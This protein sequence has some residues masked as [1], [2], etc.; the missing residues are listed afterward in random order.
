MRS[1]FTYIA[2]LLLAVPLHAMP[3]REKP[4]GVNTGSDSIPIGLLVTDS[5]RTEIITAAQLA[6]DAANDQGGTGEVPF[7]LVVRSTEGP[8]GAGSKESVSLVYDDNV[9]VIVG[10][11]DGRNGHV[12]EQVATKS[13]LVYLETRATESTLSQ[14]FVPYFK[15]ILPNDDQQA[16]AI[17]QRVRRQ[18]GGRVA[19]LYDQVFDHLHAARSFT[20]MA[21]RTGHPDPMLL[22]VDTLGT[23]PG[24]LI[25]VLH[26]GHVNNLVVPYRTGVT[27]MMIQEVRQYLPQI[28]V[29]GTLGLTAAMVPGDPEWQK[30]EGVMAISPGSGT[31]AG[32]NLFSKK[33]Y[34]KTGEA[35]PVELVFTYDGVSMVLQAIR[36]AGTDRESVKNELSSMRYAGITGILSFDEMG[37]RIGKIH[38]YRIKEGQLVPGDPLSFR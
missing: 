18:N 22:S 30:L 17:L 34:E 37:N 24:N 15:R 8:W 31:D 12:A 33:F 9:V 23:D 36:N 29:Y 28:T 5:T 19:V 10:A 27:L 16:E 14:A 26:Q 11:L 13:H 38:F 32:D 7:R 2:G 25:S 35:P 6:I 20:S 1:V 21:D 3:V 4:T